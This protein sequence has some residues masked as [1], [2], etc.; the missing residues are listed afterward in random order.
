LIAAK[1]QGL[2]KALLGT[3]WPDEDEILAELAKRAE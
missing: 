1:D 2:L 3:G